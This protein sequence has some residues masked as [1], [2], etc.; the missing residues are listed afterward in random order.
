MGNLKDDSLWIERMGDVIYGE[1]ERR[2]RLLDRAQVSEVAEYEYRRIHLGQRLEPLPALIIT[3]DEFTQMF[4]EHGES[5][6]IIDEIGR[7]GRALNVGMILG[8]QRLGHEMQ[9][10]IMANIPIRVGLRT[11]DAGES[12]SIIGTDEAKHLPEKPAGAGLLRVQGRDRLV[13]F[14]SSF[15]RKVYHPPRR[16]AAE[17]VRSQAGYMAPEAGRGDGGV[18]RNG[19]RCRWSAD[20]RD[21]GLHRLAARTDPSARSPDV[22]PT[23]GS[24][25]GGP[26]GAPAAAQTLA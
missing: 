12:M 4:L 26:A 6:K 24:V 19:A 13:R 23:A 8:S 14:Q 15:V 5:K 17:A 18:H 7:Q 10:G 16:M 3:I 9:G 22:A 11:L 20:P 21:R 25:A 1:L 2:K